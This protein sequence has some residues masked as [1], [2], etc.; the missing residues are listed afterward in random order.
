MF[1]HTKALFSYRFTHLKEIK[2]T[3]MTYNMCS[4]FV[5]MQNKIVG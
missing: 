2:V 3:S 5:M 4:H 1:A